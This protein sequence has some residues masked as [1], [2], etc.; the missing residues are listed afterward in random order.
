MEQ[1]AGVYPEPPAED[2]GRPSRAGPMAESEFNLQRDALIEQ[3]IALR[4]RL[5]RE[6]E[7]RDCAMDAAAS[8]FM[9]LDMKRP[10]WPIVYVNRA[11]VRD[12]GYTRE[13]VLGRSASDFIAVEHSKVQLEQMDDAIRRGVESRT[14]L[15]GRR[16]DGSEF[17]TGIFLGP[18]RDAEGNVTHYLLVGADITKRLEEEQNKRKLQ[19]RLY[20]EMQERE[21]MGLELHLARKLESVGRLAAGIAHEINT[22]IQY[23]GDSVHF[24]Q[25]AVADL[26]TLLK[27]Y[28][29]AFR[30]LAEGA[31]AAQVVERAR[32]LEA[33]ADLDFLTT[34]VPK[35]FERTLEGTVRVAGIVRAMKEFAHPD[36]SE[37]SLADINHALETTLIVATNEYKYLATVHVSLEPLP[38]V[39][40]LISEL[41][42]VFLN[43]IVNA[44]H[45]I[46]ESGKDFSAGRI[47]VATSADAGRV[48]VSIGDN[49]CGIPQE[50]LEK[51]FDPFFTTKEVGKG[52]GQG[53]AIARSI[54]IEKH[55][56]QIEVQSEPGK[57]T[58]FLLHL[59]IA[60]R[61]KGQES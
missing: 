34:E 26:E 10:G 19:D 22:P 38:P 50:N 40:C 9:M 11:I 44:A 27:G 55:G 14:E 25:S 15:R 58:K 51:I 54:V 37:Q 7:L 46:E 20:S 17:W 53:L 57:G 13:E 48:T 41:N 42:Q 59:P 12:F 47:E 31:P 35:A 36:A 33:A 45:A 16:K 5:E 21:R 3:E 43:L 60:G 8:H 52:T 61:D 2:G 29:D 24:L 23:V 6:L 49:G 18:I 39:M 56:G 30:S 32:G 1:K 28:R 4:H